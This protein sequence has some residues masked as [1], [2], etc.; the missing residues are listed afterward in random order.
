MG[1]ESLP[2]ISARLKQSKRKLDDDGFQVSSKKGPKTSSPTQTN[3]ELDNKF[4]NLLNTELCLGCSAEVSAIL[5]H[6]ARKKVCQVHYDM[7]KLR[8][9]AKAKANV[10]NRERV[11]R[12]RQAAKAQDVEAFSA[13]QLADTNRY[14]QAARERDPEAFRAAHR[15]SQTRYEQAAKDADLEGFRAKNAAAKDRSRKKQSIQCNGTEWGRIRNFRGKYQEWTC[16][17]LS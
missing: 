14:Q 8:Q 13:A 1:S 16:L 4:E 5:K 12:S 2:S 9:E 11:A 6:L 7:D 15:E 10:K 17:C 3:I